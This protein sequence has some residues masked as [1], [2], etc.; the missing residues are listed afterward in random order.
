MNKP[1]NPKP[2]SIFDIHIPYFREYLLFFFIKGA[3]LISN[4]DLFKESN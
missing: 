1:I 4:L 3:V 2:A